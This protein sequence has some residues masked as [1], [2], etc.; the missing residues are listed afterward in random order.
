MN[1]L[2]LDL[3]K[4]IEKNF[5]MKILVHLRQACIVGMGNTYYVHPLAA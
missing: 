3:L 1:D 4:P 5:G 2:A